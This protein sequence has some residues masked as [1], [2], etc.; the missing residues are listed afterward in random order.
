[1]TIRFVVTIKVA[2]KQGT[3]PNDMKEQLERNIASGI[4]AGLLTDSDFEAEVDA[5]KVTVEE[6]WWCSR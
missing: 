5:H 2:Y 6:K 1:M 4:N 3:M